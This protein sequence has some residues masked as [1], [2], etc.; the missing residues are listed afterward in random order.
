[1]TTHPEFENGDIRWWQLV[2]LLAIVGL[3]WILLV[4]LYQAR[5]LYEWWVE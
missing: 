2:L 3:V 1:M 5:R 4:P